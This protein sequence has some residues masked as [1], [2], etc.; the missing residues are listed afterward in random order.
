V[1]EKGVLQKK[2]NLKREDSYSRTR[3]PP[4]HKKKTPQT[5]PKKTPGNGW[6]DWRRKRTAKGERGL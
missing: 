6:V 5:Q 1:R 3:K 2:S 4:H